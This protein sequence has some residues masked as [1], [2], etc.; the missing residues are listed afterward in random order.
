MS[1]KCQT[2][3]FTISKFSTH[4]LSTKTNISCS[5]ALS[6][7]WKSSVFLLLPHSKPDLMYL[8]LLVMP[9]HP[10]THP[11]LQWFIAWSIALVSSVVSWPPLGQQGVSVVF[12]H[13]ARLTKHW[14][15]HYS[16]AGRV[17]LKGTS[18]HIISLL[19]TFQCFSMAFAIKL[20]SFCVAWKLDDFFQHFSLPPTHPPTPNAGIAGHRKPHW[21]C[22][23]TC[24]RLSSLCKFPVSGL[25]S[26][27]LPLPLSLSAIT[28]QCSTLRSFHRN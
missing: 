10:Q 5:I 18:F 8:E 27:H 26:S 28:T 14:S 4:H 22:W 9:A 6:I 11:A 25:P 23:P 2:G 24:N 20:K 1:F 16:E 17:F 3:N 21:A 7:T 13:W 12:V 15:F 19:K